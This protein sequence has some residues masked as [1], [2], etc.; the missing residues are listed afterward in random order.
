MTTP[1]ITAQNL[2]SVAAQVDA[3]LATLR[4]LLVQLDQAERAAHMALVNARQPLNDHLTGRSRISELARARL[5]FGTP[6]GLQEASPASLA[7]I[8]SAAY[9]RELA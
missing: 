7:S 4:P 1:K 5:A 8:I 9:S 6:G 3:A 2:Q